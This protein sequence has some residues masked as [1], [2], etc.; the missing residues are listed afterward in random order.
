RLKPPAADEDEEAGEP[1]PPRGIGAAG[2]PERHVYCL[3]LRDFN[4]HKVYVEE[5]RRIAAECR[6][7]REA[8][9]KQ[10]VQGQPTPVQLGRHLRDEGPRP[11]PQFTSEQL[12]QQPGRR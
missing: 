1:E 12:L 11:A 6:E 2:V 10:W 5:V 8:N 4:D 9:L 3:D 7:R